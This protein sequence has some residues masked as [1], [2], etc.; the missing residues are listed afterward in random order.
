MKRFTLLISLLIMAG[1]TQAQI[2]SQYIETNSG[3]SPKGIEIWNNTDRGH[4]LATY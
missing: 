4:Y 1:F 2:I 3:T